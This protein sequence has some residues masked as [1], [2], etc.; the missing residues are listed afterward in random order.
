MSMSI[1]NAMQNLRAVARRWL[2][3]RGA[4]T[5]RMGLAAVLLAAPLAHAG[6]DNGDFESGNFSGWTMTNYS[7]SGIATFPPTQKSHLNLQPPGDTPTN[8]VVSA[9]PGTAPAPDAPGG[10]LAVPF[11]GSYSARINAR[12]NNN[13]AARRPPWRWPTWIRRTARSTCAWPLRP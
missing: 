10:V 8:Q 1:M 11:K 12:G 9:P 2:P 5:R 4:A 13:R 3:G 6:F 7:N